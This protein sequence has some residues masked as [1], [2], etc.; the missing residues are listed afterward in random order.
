MSDLSV[1]WMS[2]SDD[3]DS[4]VEVAV[5][6]IAELLPCAHAA[7]RSW[8]PAS[9]IMVAQQCGG[10]D[11]FSGCAGNPASGGAVKRLIAAGGKSL[12]AE[13]DELIGAEA[14]IL[15]RTASREVEMK[16]R[17]LVARYHGYTN[18]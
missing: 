6:F 14:Y 3:L 4:D 7:T 1:R 11:S 16:F 5:K 15:S 12:L 9:A 13:T 8:Q 17:E 18:R 2:M 10:S